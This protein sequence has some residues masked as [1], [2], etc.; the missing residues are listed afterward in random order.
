M[1]WLE[2]LTLHGK[3]CTLE[4]LSPNHHG[5]L[6]EAVKDGELWNLWFARVPSPENMQSEIS[7]RLDLQAKGSMLPFA[8]L[9][10]KTKKAIGM[11]TF[12]WIDSVNKRVDIG[13]TWY[14]KSYQRTAFNTECKSLLLAH[15][16]EQLVCIYVGIRVHK[17]NHR[18]RE[19]VERL[20]ATLEGIIRNY[21]VMPNG[22]IADM[23]FYSIL[24]HEW[25]NVKAHLNWLLS[26]PREA[27]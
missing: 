13:W 26:K 20:G 14:A 15:A 2:P 12:C 23:C 24:P 25:P 16:F 6:V 1:A 3:Y 8:V 5:E 22:H 19:A 7:R 4:P 18:S 27:K 10:N 21:C 11:T 9:D 17:L